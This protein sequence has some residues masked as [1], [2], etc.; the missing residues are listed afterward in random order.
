M[1][2]RKR[3]EAAGR[4]GIEGSRGRR[5][6]GGAGGTRRWR[7]GA[8]PEWF[9]PLPSLMIESD[10]SRGGSALERI[11]KMLIDFFDKDA[12]QRFNLARFLIDRTIPFG[13]KA[14]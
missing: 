3:R 12:L 8:R 13:R 10:S 2:V 9:F 11:P 7:H 1:Q 14:R 6:F 5:S 4:K